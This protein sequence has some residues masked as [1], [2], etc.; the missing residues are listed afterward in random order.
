MNKI[1]ILFVVLGMCLAI[2]NVSAQSNDTIQEKNGGSFWKNW[3]FETESQ[4]AGSIGYDK[5]RLTSAINVV[6]EGEG[7]LSYFAY[8]R[9]EKDALGFFLEESD[10]D[11]ILV[12]IEELN[13]ELESDKNSPISLK[14]KYT[15]KCGV[16][17]W[18]TVRN[19]YV[20][21]KISHKLDYIST[22]S[23]NDDFNLIDFFKGLKIRIAD[24]KTQMAQ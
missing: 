12:G 9:F 6:Q 8:V 16:E 2:P 5:Y 17:I 23:L 22:Y 24:A 20:A 3:E 18:Y 14:N 21:W 10:I 11:E 7:C 15:S 4:K 19:K 13:K 1:K